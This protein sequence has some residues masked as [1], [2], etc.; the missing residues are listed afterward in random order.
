[1]PAQQRV[2]QILALIEDRGF[3]SVRE[4]SEACGVSEM[5]IRRDLERLERE[6]R[7]QRT[8]GGAILLPTAAGAESG[9]PAPSPFSGLVVDR[10]DVLIAASVDPRFDR[11]LLDRSERRGI[12]V[13]AESAPPSV[14]QAGGS[15][16]PHAARKTV[17]SVD[18]YR[19]ARLLGGWAGEYAREHFDGR[20]FV[21]DLT[22]HFAN[23]RARSEGFWAGLKATLPGARV[24]FSID[25][26][27]DPEIAYRLTHDSLDVHPDINII[28]A[29][30]DA[31]A[32]GALR[33]CRER[34]VDPDRLLL[35]TFGLEGD[36]FK[37]VLAT[38]GYCRA[39]LAMFPEIA[40]PACIEAAIAAYQKQPLPQHL[41]TPH[42]IVTPETLA[43]YFTC[44]DGHWH[45]RRDGLA[46]RLSLPVDMDMQQPQP[47]DALPRRI[48]FVVPF[49]EHE[50]YQNLIA[51]MAAYAE[52][53]GISLEV[54]DAAE[55]RK[56]DTVLRQRSIAQAAASQIHA[57]DVVLIGGGQIT[58]YLAEELARPPAETVYAG[59]P[60]ND[61]SH[62]GSITVITNSIPVFEILRDR[63][64]M[65]VILTGGQYRTG[66]GSLLGP[67]A[68]SALRELRADRL[69]LAVNGIS[70]EFGLSQA[71]I[72]EAAMAQALIRAA[73]EVILLADHG[74]FGRESVIQIAPMSAAHKLIT[75]NGLP[76]SVRL[77][78]SKL[79]IEV[80]TAKA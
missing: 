5:T 23:T 73:R 34:G 20:A 55:I 6:R 80:I 67:A 24:L 2:Q 28:F 59:S 51:C 38:A 65:T 42:A 1:M 71:D 64:N 25:A 68:Q 49:L 41:L 3:V 61:P 66:S 12:P 4:L 36:T 14:V 52:R 47:R 78:L 53:L 56:A 50:W 48:G 16:E 19:A 76:A 57:G 75:D 15:E 77:E 9:P 72:D 32:L 7:L 27:S 35:L 40:G 39:A 79:G 58:A 54:V 29:I 30:N 10:V 46:G 21:L 45:L 43:D 17:V 37:D 31:T 18:N 62:K 44:E 60:A 74:R 63:P 11:V 33:A 13:I 70:L 26:Q 69:F 22:Y 8:Y